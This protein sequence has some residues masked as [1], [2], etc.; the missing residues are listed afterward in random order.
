MSSTSNGMT[1]W[2]YERLLGG[3]DVVP[4]HV[5]ARDGLGEVGGGMSDFLTDVLGG[6]LEGLRPWT[7]RDGIRCSTDELVPKQIRRK[8]RDMSGLVESMER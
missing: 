3:L 5:S 4:V 1:R 7:T 6:V 2:T 8:S